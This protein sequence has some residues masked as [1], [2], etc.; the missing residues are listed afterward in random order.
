MDDQDQSTVMD[1]ETEIEDRRLEQGGQVA[2]DPMAFP[3]ALLQA[4][5]YC[6]PPQVDE[7]A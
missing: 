3:M 1:H 2:S 7:A 6:P 4:L 5:R